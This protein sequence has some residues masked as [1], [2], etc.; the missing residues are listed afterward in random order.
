MIIIFKEFYMNLME[1]T[2]GTLGWKT[3]IN[4]VYQL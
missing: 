1:K 4:L 2:Y 3:D